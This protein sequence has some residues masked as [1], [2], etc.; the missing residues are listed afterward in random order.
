MECLRNVMPRCSSQERQ[1][2]LHK[3]L[4]Y[5]QAFRLRFLLKKRFLLATW[6]LGQGFLPLNL[7]INLN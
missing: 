7:L 1:R 2:A 6:F 3:S 5:I 4:M